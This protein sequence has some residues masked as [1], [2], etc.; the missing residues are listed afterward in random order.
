LRIGIFAAIPFCVVF[1]QL[2][3]NYLKE[4]WPHSIPRAAFV[5]ICATFLLISPTWLAL[6]SV[7]PSNEADHFPISTAVA[8]PGNEADWKRTKPD[9]M[10]N[11]Q[12]D[13]ALLAGLPKSYVMTDINSGPAAIIF[14][15]HDVVGGPYHRNERAILDMVDFFSTD[16]EAPERIARARGIDYVAYCEP[17]RPLSEKEKASDSL[18]VHIIVG[19][20][21]AWLR[22]V[23]A[24]GDRLHVFKV[25]PD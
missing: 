19:T 4:K 25:E 2:L 6:S 13:F 1:W 7:L 12:S 14:T 16:L 22:R 21:P 5:Q 23:S 20:E 17:S 18:L 8:S 10:C 15:S 24:R 11:R 9:P 3:W